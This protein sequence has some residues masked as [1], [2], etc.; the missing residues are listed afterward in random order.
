MAKTSKKKAPQK[1]AKNYEPKVK[2]EGA[3]ED[4]M[5]ISTT[6]AGTKKKEKKK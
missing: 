1:R 5:K 2:F 6:G 3:F 4:I